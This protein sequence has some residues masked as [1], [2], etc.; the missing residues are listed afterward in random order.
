MC[1]VL[2]FH[3]VDVWN[4]KSFMISE[5]PFTKRRVVLF[6]VYDELSYQPARFERG[7]LRQGLYKFFRYVK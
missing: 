3:E 2:D 4:D 5:R 6:L 7:E 1:A